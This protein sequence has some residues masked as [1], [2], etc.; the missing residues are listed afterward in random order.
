MRFMT[1]HKNTPETEAGE[2]PSPEVMAKMGA[3]IGEQAANGRFLGGEGLGRSASRTRLVFRAGRGAIEHGPYAGSNEL[4][5][6]TLLLAVRSREEAIGWAERYGKLLVDGELELGPVTEPWDLGFMAKP[7]D[8]PLRI[9]ML[10]KG[11]AASEASQPAKRKAALTRLRTEMSKAGVL[12][13]SETLKPSAQGKR[14]RF[15]NGALSVL[16]GPFL[17]SK[18]LIGGY[19]VMQLPSLE[20]A[21]ALCTPFAEILGGTLEIDIRPLYEPDEAP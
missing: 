20:D 14:L 7:S 16:D 9:L 11:D 13:G 19:S 18:E 6:A 5:A 8:A 4:I 2:L 12:L 21:L 10:V 15:R 3:F 1:M 17:E